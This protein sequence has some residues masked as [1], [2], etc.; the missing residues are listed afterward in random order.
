MVPCRSSRSRRCPRSGGSHNPFRYRTARPGRRRSSLRCLSRHW[1]SLPRGRLPPQSLRLKSL[2]LKSL[3]RQRR[4]P[5][6]RPRP[7]RRYPSRLSPTRHRG[8]RF[9]SIHHS[10]TR[11]ARARGVSAPFLVGCA[12]V[13]IV[14]LA[15]GSVAKEGEEL[16]CAR[17][18]G[19]RVECPACVA[20]DIFVEPER[21][22][23]LNTVLPEGGLWTD[24]DPAVLA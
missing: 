18:V 17:A 10:R 9:R 15:L 1:Q 4:P 3:R 6:S 19:R 13:E 23:S 12:A 24:H 22:A 2:R 8:S 7:S 20:V 11:R 16:G 5:R 21:L 14:H